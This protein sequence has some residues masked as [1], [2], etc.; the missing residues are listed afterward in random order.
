MAYKKILNENSPVFD[1]GFGDNDYWLISDVIKDIYMSEGSMAVLLDFE[2]VLDDLDI[3]AYQNWFYGELVDGPDI[4]RYRT[5]C[6]FMWPYDLM[7]DPSAARRLTALDCQVQY[8][9]TKIK[10][11]RKIQNPGD[12]QPGTRLAKMEERPVW[13]VKITMPK[14]LMNDIK[15]GSLELENQN[16]DLADLEDAYEEDLDKDQ[17][18]DQESPAS[19]ARELGGG[20]QPGDLG[21]PAAASPQFPGGL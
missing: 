20:P 14:A 11:P 12:F 8:K 19:Q 15:T 17:Y 1:N 3:Y 7:P 2:R 16:I 6:V 4:G 9:Q 21:G 5:S 13:L 18:Q 10:I